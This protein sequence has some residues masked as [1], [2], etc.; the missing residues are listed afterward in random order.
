MRVTHANSVP[1]VIFRHCPFPVHAFL[2]NVLMFGKVIAVCHHFNVTSYSV[3]T[4]FVAHAFFFLFSQSAIG[5]QS[6]IWPRNERT[7][8]LLLNNPLLPLFASHGGSHS[9]IDYVPLITSMPPE[10]CFQ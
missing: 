8:A 5:S 3:I 2:A 6:P 7:A 10:V 4:P 9:F 1:D